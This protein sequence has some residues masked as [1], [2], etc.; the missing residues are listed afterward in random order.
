MKRI[1][2]LNST[3]DIKGGRPTIHEFPDKHL[4]TIYENLNNSFG[5]RFNIINLQ[6]SKL[7]LTTNNNKIRVFYN[8]EWYNVQIQTELIPGNDKNDNY[9]KCVIS[10]KKVIDNKYIYIPWHLSIYEAKKK[11]TFIHITREN[12]KTAT[13]R[14][15]KDNY[16]NLN[17]HTQTL[18]DKINE[19]I[20][21]S[22]IKNKKEQTY[23]DDNSI[24]GIINTINSNTE[25]NKLLY[26]MHNSDDIEKNLT[27]DEKDE[28]KLLKFFFRE[29]I[30][31]ILLEF[32]YKIESPDN[33]KSDYRTGK[34]NDYFD[35]HNKINFYHDLKFKI[36][37]SHY[38]PLKTMKYY[39]IVNDNFSIF[40]NKY[41]PDMSYEEMI[42]K[43]NEKV[44]KYIKDNDLT[45]EN[46]IK[47]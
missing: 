46:I 5:K 39:S 2:L 32:Y 43:A 22:S 11:V 23:I 16:N 21:K 24:L 9:F 1:I 4:K 8:N 37:K 3:F 47:I 15:K 7:N 45:K 33:K 17:S 44:E 36:N 26:S 35:I 41:D 6:Y 29:G 27:S 30:I 25:Y 31:H 34:I 18:I 20:E 19:Y 42:D 38:D 40:L 13:N 28:I 12:I 14:D 10:Y